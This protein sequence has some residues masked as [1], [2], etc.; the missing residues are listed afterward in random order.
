MS[1]VYNIAT[2]NNRLSQVVNALDAATPPGSFQLL[3]SGGNI[4]ASM[5]MQQP[6]GSV[7]GGVLS[8]F[9]L[10]LIAPAAAA[11]GVATGAQF[12]DGNGNVVISGLTANNDFVISPNSNVTAGQTIALTFAQII[13]N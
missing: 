5:Q 10:S 1:V 8:F 13:G 7:T 6:M 4:L 3:D 12:I 11:T 9:G 2:R